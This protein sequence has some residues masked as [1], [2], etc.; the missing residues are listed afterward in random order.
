MTWDQYNRL[1]IELFA[2]NPL[3]IVNEG[4]WKSFVNEMSKLPYF[5]KS[6]IP[7]AA[8]FPD[9]QGWAKAMTGILSITKGH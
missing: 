2:T 8:A 6:G 1:M 9:W 5:T 3:P 4:N 7:Q